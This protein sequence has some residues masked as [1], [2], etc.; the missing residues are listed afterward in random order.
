VEETYIEEITNANA[1]L[2]NDL[3]LSSLFSPSFLINIVVA[4]NNKMK[5][6][7]ERIHDTQVA[8]YYIRVHFN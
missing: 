8:K 1:G 6:L 7:S 4:C 5:T 2:A 3:G